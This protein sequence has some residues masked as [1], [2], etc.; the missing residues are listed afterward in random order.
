[1][2]NKD[3]AQI[4]NVITHMLEDSNALVF[5]E[6]IKTTEYL[7]ILM[8]KSIKQQKLKQFVGLLT[9]KYKETKTA[10]IAAVNKALHTIIKSKAIPIQGLFDHMLNTLAMNSKNARVK[11]LII[12]KC[13]Y[14]IQ[15][16]ALLRTDEAALAGIFKQSKDKLISLIQ[17]DT[18][19]NVRDAAV[20]LLATFKA[21][22]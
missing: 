1:M 9:D 18:N 22:I 15:E 13:D 12:E 19:A 11:Q 21:Y 5:M 16:E 17:K 2:I 10:P 6:A 7:S 8:A 14:T 20:A 4:F 3:Y